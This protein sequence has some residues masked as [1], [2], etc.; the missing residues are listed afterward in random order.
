M[1]ESTGP[2]AWETEDSLSAPAWDLNDFKQALRAAKMTVPAVK[3]AFSGK[4]NEDV[5]AAMER[6]RKAHSTT[7]EDAFEHLKVSV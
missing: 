2:P 6:W 7:Y 3:A 5:L 4:E 1:K